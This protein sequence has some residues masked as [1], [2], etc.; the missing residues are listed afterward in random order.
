[1][2]GPYITHAEELLFEH[3]AYI[4]KEFQDCLMTTAAV[5]GVSSGG[6]G[7]QG[8]YPSGPV[9]VGSRRVSRDNYENQDMLMDASSRASLKT[10]P[11]GNYPVACHYILTLIHTPHL[12]VT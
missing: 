2:K 6:S 4:S 10:P 1:M 3:F 12:Y 11:T 9:P 8:G 5:G 7:G